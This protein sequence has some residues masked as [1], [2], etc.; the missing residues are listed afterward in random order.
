M[1]NYNIIPQNRPANLVGTQ[2]RQSLSSLTAALA[3]AIVLGSFAQE[4]QVFSQNIV[5]D[6]NP[7]DIIITDSGDA[8]QGGAILK[9]NPQTGE[10]SV[11]SRGGYLGFFGYP[12]GVA[13]DRNGQLIVANEACLL[14]IDPNT[15]QQTLIRDA[16]GAPGG[17]W[18]V[19]FDHRGDILV[20]AESAILR[21]NPLTGETLVVSSGGNFSVVLNVA[22]GANESDLF[23]T[24]VRY[25]DAVGGWVGEIIRVNRHNG[26]QTVISQGGYLT[27]LLGIAVNGNDIYVTGLKGQDQNFG[28]GQV[29]HVDAQ[30]GDQRMVSQGEYLV[31]PVG[32]AVDNDGQLIVADPYT[33]NPQS[34]DLSSGGY[35]GAVIRIDPTT[36]GQTPIARGHGSFVNPCGVAVIPSY[37][38]PR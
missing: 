17:F 20:A 8:I 5:A 36:G 2:A 30:T 11:I 29:T 33:I 32:I 23:V 22:V 18:N 4:P 38:S 1:K 21:V 12:N 7:G 34:P 10:Q 9:E 6:L 25:D 31:R 37:G 28:T 35:D 27:Y 26:R 24:N 19:A 13:I 3:A 16:R 15:G 14:R